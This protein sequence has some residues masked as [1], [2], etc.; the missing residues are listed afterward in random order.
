MKNEQIETAA[1]EYAAKHPESY[2]AQDDFIAGANYALEKGGDEILDGVKVEG[3]HDV[4]EF[5]KDGDPATP[6]KQEAVEFL[7]W[8]YKNEYLSDDS[9]F[10]T[11]ELYAKWKEGK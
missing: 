4:N 10:T 5:Y 6:Q 1:N 8:C 11:S 2:Y 9:G 7:N 3:Y